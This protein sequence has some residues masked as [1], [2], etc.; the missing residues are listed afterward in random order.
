LYY[1]PP[2][3]L[4]GLLNVD[5]RGDIYSLGMSF[6]EMLAGRTPF[7]KTSSEFKILKAIDA[8]QFPPVNELNYDVP[9]GLSAIIAKS[10]ERDPADRYQTAQEMLVALDQWER[11]PQAHTPV[12]P[13]PD[14][15]A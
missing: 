5:H 15:E 14:H 13:I 11:N 1:M 3:Q 7:D 10:I 8:A 4:E 6:Y 2:E 9:P 12:P